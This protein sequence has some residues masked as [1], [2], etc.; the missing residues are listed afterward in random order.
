MLRRAD[1]VTRR[2]IGSVQPPLAGRV[3]VP[4]ERRI[5][6][7]D[8]HALDV[9]M[10]VKAFGAAFAPDAGIADTAPGRSRIEP[11]VIVDPDDAAFYAGRDPMGARDVAGA[12]RGCPSKR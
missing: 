1:S 3:A 12:D 9:E 4:V 2:A 11:V 5:A 10:I 8:H 6:G 7:C